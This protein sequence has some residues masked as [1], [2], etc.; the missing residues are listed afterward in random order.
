MIKKRV[1]AIAKLEEVLDTVVEFV[2]VHVRHLQRATAVA[3][4][5]PLAYINERLQLSSAPMMRPS[6][7]LGH[8]LPPVRAVPVV[9][10]RNVS[11]VLP[12]HVGFAVFAAAACALHL[13]H[14][15][16]V[17]ARWCIACHYHSDNVLVTPERRMRAHRDNDPRCVRGTFCVDCLETLL[18]WE[19]NHICE[20]MMA[21]QVFGSKRDAAVKQDV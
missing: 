20:S 18:S 8:D 9:V 14:V 4:V 12:V 10:A 17:M 13:C 5:L 16:I 2:L 3:N 15:A 21:I 6:A 1:V 11:T 19:T 7:R